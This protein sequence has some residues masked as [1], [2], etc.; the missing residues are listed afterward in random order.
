MLVKELQ[1]L[2][3]DI[4]VLDEDGTEIELKDDDEDDYQ[5]SIS[6]RGRRY[7]GYDAARSP[8]SPRG[9]TLEGG[10]RRRDAGDAEEWT[11]R[12]LLG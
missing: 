5:P 2:C 1:S 8:T 10:Q 4:Q 9:Y 12:R 6:A 3:L 11:T 7:Y